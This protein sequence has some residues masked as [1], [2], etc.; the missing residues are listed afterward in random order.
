ME[1]PKEFCFIFYFLILCIDE[2][3]LLVL[4]KVGWLFD[5]F[6]PDI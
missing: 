5:P 2:Y 3:H 6:P 1:L 4:H